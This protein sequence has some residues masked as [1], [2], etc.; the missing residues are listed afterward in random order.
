MLNADRLNEEFDSNLRKILH[1]FTLYSKFANHLK[2][3]C[4]LSP[5]SMTP[6]G[7]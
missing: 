2:V 7:V 4:R 3:I 5:P 1:E 6:I